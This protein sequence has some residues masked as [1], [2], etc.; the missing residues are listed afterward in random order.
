MNFFKV[1]LSEVWR[2][3]NRFSVN[4]FKQCNEKPGT[5]GKICWK[6]HMFL[7]YKYTPHTYI[8]AEHNIG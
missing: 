8:C 4:V 2:H 1:T 3:L 6:K 5:E 7:H